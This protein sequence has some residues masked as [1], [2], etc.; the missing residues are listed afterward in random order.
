MK[1]AA[2]QASP[3]LFW[4]WRLLETLARLGGSERGLPS[5]EAAGLERWGRNEPAPPRRF[6]AGREI[7]NYLANPL[8]LILVVASAI[9]AAF[10]QVASAVIIALVLSLSVALNF[11]QTYCYRCYRM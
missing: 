8:V 9:S 2:D 11:T 1:P 4:T 6:E 3:D 10:G 7:A 5:E